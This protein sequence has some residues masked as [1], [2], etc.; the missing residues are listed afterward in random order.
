MLEGKRPPRKLRATSGGDLRSESRWYILNRSLV[1]FPAGQVAEVDTDSHAQASTW[2]PR[3]GSNQQP[4]RREAIASRRPILGEFEHQVMATVRNCG[5]D[6]YGLRIAEILLGIYS[7]SL[8]IA[9]VYVTLSRLE[10]K[11][12]LSSQMDAPRHMRGGRARRVFKLQGKG[13]AALEQS[14]AVR[15][16]LAT[17]VMPKGVAVDGN[18]RGNFPKR[19]T[20]TSSA[21]AAG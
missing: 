20:G 4:D 7:G 17:S 19:A 16:A 21:P 2:K 6:A 1:G 8:A 18:Q 10:K 9:Q 13:D 5:E 11:G 15:S 14:T 3:A 12:F